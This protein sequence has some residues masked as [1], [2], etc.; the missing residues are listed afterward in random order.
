MVWRNRL[1]PWKPKCMHSCRGERAIEKLGKKG[2]EKENIDR[3]DCV[4]GFISVQD[5]EL[6]LLTSEVTAVGD[7]FT[8]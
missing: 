4:C 7:L 1:S 8:N 2:D 6:K 5:V 3:R